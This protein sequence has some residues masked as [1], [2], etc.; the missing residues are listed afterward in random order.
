MFLCAFPGVNP[1]AE[2]RQAENGDWSGRE[3]SP[4]GSVITF[5]PRTRGGGEGCN[6][7]RS[8]RNGAVVWTGVP[9]LPARVVP[10][11]VPVR[12]SV[13]LIEE[14]PGGSTGELPS[15]LPG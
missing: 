5:D 13:V 3:G 9:P 2:R 12:V 6:T 11:S 14:T 8:P 10:Q 7:D 1:A 4:P 15:S